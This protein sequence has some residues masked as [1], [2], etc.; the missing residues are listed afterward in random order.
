MGKTP[1]RKTRHHSRALAWRIPGQKG[2]ASCGPWG[3]KDADRLSDLA[4]EDM[5]MVS[6]TRSFKKL[7]GRAMGK[8]RRA[9]AE[10]RLTPTG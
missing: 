6:V 8:R 7:G 9:G 5:E 1:W 10:T 4:Q 3:L 2:L